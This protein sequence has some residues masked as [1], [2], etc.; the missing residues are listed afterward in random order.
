M[1]S[2]GNY[3]T[4]QFIQRHLSNQVKEVSEASERL[5]SGKRVNSASDDPS[6]IGSISRLNANIASLSKGIQNAGEAKILSQNADSGLN[7]INDLLSRLRELAVKGSSST[8]TASDRTT[9]QVEIDAYL[10]E[11]DSLTNT[12]MFNAIKLLDGTTDKVSFMLGIDKDANLDINLVK[13][14]STALGL[15]GSS[16]VKEFTSG[17]VSSFNYS[18]NLAAS[19]IKINGQ[20][21]LAATLTNNLTSGNNTANVLATKINANTNS[22][23]AEAIG[24]NKLTS[25]AKSSLTMSNT[26]TIN[27]DLISVQTSL[28][29]L[30]TEINQEASGVSASLNSDNTITLSNTTGNDIVIGG[31]APSE[32][33]FT[34]GT[35]LGYIK[36][37]NVDKTFVK[38]EAMTKSNGYTDN[39]GNVDDLARFGF[40][41][42]DTSTVIRSDLVS[43]NALT[44]SHDIK[45]N[46]I[47]IGA[48]SSSSAAAKA[49]AINAV[50]S[51]TN[52]TGAAENLVTFTT[53]NYTENSTAASTISINGN[54]INFSSVTNDSGAITAINNAS[55]GDIIASTNSAGELQLAS[56]SGADITVAQTSTLGVFNEG[57]Q[58]ITGATISLAT[59]HTFKGQLLLTHK[60][61]DI[62]KISGADVAE[63][64]LQAQASS[65]AS[66]PGS[67]L[68]VS[69]VS[70]ATSAI[71]SIDTA[72]DTIANTR[73]EFGAAENRVDH[74]IN[75]LTDTNIFMSSRLSK[76]EDADFALETARFTKSQ[77]MSKAA[78]SMLAQANAN[79]EVL[80]RLIN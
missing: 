32:A 8:L 57:Y 74:R 12:T 19:D 60:A 62:V 61:D 15:S 7:S 5:S 9:L 16:G 20:N 29:N 75:V 21:A 46:D 68:S 54:A 48:S 64:G 58:D 55:I 78:S 11:I 44:N 66:T 30:V 49:L 4:S 31:N 79:S 47:S 69:S 80:L 63:L 71:T 3:S 25:A 37:T 38:I 65:S 70:N 13:S 76:I 73:A 36:L 18:T 23:G 39:S 17:R 59:S 2:I 35:Y 10:K 67:I 26:F 27:T 77:I 34:A 41:E 53:I 22:H 56:A 6:I 28:E 52:V 33:G 43:T 14:D 51:S 24:F 50:S 1:I 72:I 42:I 40:N 45:I